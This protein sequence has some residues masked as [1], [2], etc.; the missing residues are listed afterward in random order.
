[1][2]LFKSRDEM[3]AILPTL[4]SFSNVLLGVI[5]FLFAARSNH[6]TA[7]SLWVTS[8][9]FMFNILGLGYRRFM[10]PSHGRDWK[11]GVEYPLI[12]F[13]RSNVFF[14][15]IAMSV[16]VLPP[17]LLAQIKFFW[18]AGNNYENQK[19]LFKHIFN[20]WF[21]NV[22]VSSFLYLFAIHVL[23]NDLQRE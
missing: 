3:H 11:N 19:S 12:D 5:G 4:F 16:V 15:L 23:A 6:E 9:T 20:V 8:Y 18:M 13:F 10:Y 22:A 1:M 17:L 2:F 7:H 21:R 14:T